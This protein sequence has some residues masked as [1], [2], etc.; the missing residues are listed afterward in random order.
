MQH[1]DGFPTKSLDGISQLLRQSC[2]ELHTQYLPELS[3]M[4]LHHGDQGKMLVA[5]VTQSISHNEPAAVRDPDVLQ[6]QADVDWALHIE[7]RLQACHEPLAEGE[8]VS[9]EPVWLLQYT[10]HPHEFKEAL[11][12][13]VPLRACREAL[14]AAHRPCTLPDSG[15]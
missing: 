10:S 2:K 12:E 13:G 7:R 1:R 6:L 5:E 11:L 4:C 14:Y 3:E 15:A 9:E 8:A